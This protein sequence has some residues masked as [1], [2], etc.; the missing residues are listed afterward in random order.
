MF[1]VQSMCVYPMQ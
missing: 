1:E